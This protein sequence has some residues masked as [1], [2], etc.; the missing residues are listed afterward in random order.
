MPL[1]PDAGLHHHFVLAGIE[2][3]GIPGGRDDGDRAAVTAVVAAAELPGCESGDDP[4]AE[5]FPS[6]S[7]P[8]S[9]PSPARTSS[10]IPSRRR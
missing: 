5:Q 4:A 7:G 3:G 9:R 6:P 1:T 8:P 10:P 2:F